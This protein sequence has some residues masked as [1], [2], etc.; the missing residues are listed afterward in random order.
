MIFYCHYPRDEYSGSSD[1]LR[2]RRSDPHLQ[3]SVI[4]KASKHACQCI[5]IFSEDQG[6]LV[7]Q[8]IADHTAESPVIVPITIATHIGNPNASAFSIP[9]TPN[10]PSPMAS[11]MKKVLFRL[12]T[13]FLNMITKSNASADMMR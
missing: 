3:A 6:Y 1:K 11:K 8:D 13:Y 9:T 4:N 10:N 12:I 5:N 2:Q 7:N